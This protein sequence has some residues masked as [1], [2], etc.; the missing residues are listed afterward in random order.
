MTEPLWTFALPLALGL[1]VPLAAAG[2]GSHP[3]RAAG[4]EIDGAARRLPA[5][6]LSLP[7]PY[8]NVT[9]GP[10]VAAPEAWGEVR[11]A[12]SVTVSGSG[13][14]SE[15]AE[16]GDALPV[17]VDEVRLALADLLVESGAFAEV[18]S[19]DARGPGLLIETRLE[20][21]TLRRS[22]QDGLGRKLATWIFLGWI[23]AW[24]HDRAYT[25]AL[26][27]VFVLKDA[28]TGE[29]LHE[30]RTRAGKA[31]DW[32]SLFERREGS[33]AFVGTV[34]WFPYFAFDS[35]P[36]AVARALSPASLDGPVRELLAALT[37][38]EVVHRVGAP[39]VQATRAGVKVDLAVPRPGTELAPGAPTAVEVVV[40]V[41][42][43]A[44][45]LAKVVI[46]GREIAAEGARF[47]AR[48]ENLRGLAPGKPVE[49]KVQLDKGG[50]FV[51]LVIRVDK[52]LGHPVRSKARSGTKP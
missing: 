41:K 20:S 34:F 52:R 38:L 48:A 26:E 13:K 25:L 51:A 3:H 14:S 36:A 4:T 8:R 42:P 5:T 17:D 11:S 19:A 30:V 10:V 2:C 43:E 32:L 24:Q 45:R 18:R 9:V 44:G 35:T 27:P 39:R 15:A 29:V 22:E 23:A 47:V 21:A 28:E 12:V 6:T 37:G 1:A 49:V 31:T 7:A 40:T 33:G 16:A 46:G 50:P